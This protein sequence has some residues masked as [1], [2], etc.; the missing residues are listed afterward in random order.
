MR[1][2]N[3]FKTQFLFIYLLLLTKLIEPRVL[4]RLA[5]GG[6]VRR[7]VAEHLAE[8]I[9]TVAVQHGKLGGEVLGVPLGEHVR[10]VLEAADAGPEAVHVGGGAEELEDLVELTD[11]GVAAEEDLAAGELGHDAADGPEID[12]GRVVLLAEEDF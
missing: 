8:E 5:G 10:V 12:G 11:F 4:K 7:V 2:R 1:E 6:A 9:N 3:L